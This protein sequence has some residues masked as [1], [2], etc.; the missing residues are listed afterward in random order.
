MESNSAMNLVFVYGYIVDEEEFAEQ[1]MKDGKFGFVERE[2]ANSQFHM[3]IIW[4][5]VSISI[6][7]VQHLWKKFQAVPVAYI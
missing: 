5:Q 7:S 1:V 6:N 3:N 2:T 4:I